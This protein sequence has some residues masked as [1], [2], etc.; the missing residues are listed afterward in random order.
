[1][2]RVGTVD[3][4]AQGLAIVRT[5]DPPDIGTTVVD[6]SLETAG[7]IVDVFG[8]VEQPYVAVTPAADRRLP[9]LLGQQLYER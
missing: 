3:R 1:M 5:D 7:R 6:E 8:P 4:T 9:E 2:E